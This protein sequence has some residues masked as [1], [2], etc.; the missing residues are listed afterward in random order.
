MT[1][2]VLS[3]CLFLLTVTLLAGCDSKPKGTA[4]GDPAKQSAVA[5]GDSPKSAPTVGKKVDGQN[6]R[7]D[8]MVKVDGQNKRDDGV[9]Q[10]DARTLIGDY[11]ED[12]KAADRKYKGRV[13][14]LKG[15]VKSSTN[16]VDAVSLYNGTKLQAEVQCKVGVDG[17]KAIKAHNLA[18]WRRE[19]KGKVKQINTGSTVV[20]QGTCKGLARKN[21]IVMDTCEVIDPVLLK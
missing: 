20:I 15:V 7:D 18:T 2:R 19:V 21:A 4:E 12:E 17:M 1:P 16:Y 6:E 11:A 3:G 14:Q 5:K 10:V 9:V 8:G 13:I